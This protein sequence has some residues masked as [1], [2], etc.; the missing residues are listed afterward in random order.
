MFI[1]YTDGACHGNPGPGAWV[2]LLFNERKLLKVVGGFQEVTTNNRMELLAAIEGLKC[3]PPSQPA[4]IHTDSQYLRNGITTWLPQWK[5]RNWKTAGKTPVK[6]RELW[7]ALDRLNHPDIEWRYVTA[8]NGILYNEICD[9]LA[10]ILI[11]HQGKV[12]DLHKEFEQLF[13]KMSRNSFTGA[14]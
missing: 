10:Q 12:A 2:A 7:E 1:I 13:W 5:R 14:V 8:H 6:N 4:V 11:K 3:L 9:R